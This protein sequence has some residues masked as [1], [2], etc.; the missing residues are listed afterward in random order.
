MDLGAVGVASECADPD[1]IPGFWN[2]TSMAAPYVA[3]L[4]ALLRSTGHGKAGVRQ[5]LLAGCKDTPEPAHEE[6]M[7]FADA[8]ASL[9]KL[10]PEETA[11]Y[12]PGL[13]RVA[14]SGVDDVPLSELGDFVMTYRREDVGRFERKRL[15]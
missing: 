1:L 9:L 11:G 6:G 13:P 7:G 10:A 2:G 5:A 14:K 12:Y 4:C 15:A 8:L 3:A